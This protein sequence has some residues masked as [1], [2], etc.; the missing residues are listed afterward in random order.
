MDQCHTQLNPPQNTENVHN[1]ANLEPIPQNIPVRQS[2]RNRIAPSYLQEY[3]CSLV[4][5]TANDSAHTSPNSIR[6]PL[7]NFLSYDKLSAN[8][9][10]FSLNISTNVEPD[11]YEEA[12]KHSRWQQAIANELAALTKTNTWILTTLPP[13]KK[14]VGC[15]WVFKIKHKADGTVERHKARLVAKGFTRTTGLD[16]LETFSP[17]VK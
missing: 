9:K 8:H 12:A 4:S 16:Y 15:K 14:A 1:Q 3:H 11:T 17:V 7:H 5:S 6:Y 2:T 13:N 10:H